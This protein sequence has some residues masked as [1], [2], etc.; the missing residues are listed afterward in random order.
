MA[1]TDTWSLHQR[2][3][4]IE[5]EEICFNKQKK[6]CWRK[7]TLVSALCIVSP[8]AQLELVYDRKCY[9]LVLYCYALAGE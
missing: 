3:A 4:E 2:Y 7:H 8:H 5:R 6:K 9:V 1:F